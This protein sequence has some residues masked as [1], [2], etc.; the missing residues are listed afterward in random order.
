MGIS[1]N[2]NGYIYSVN[3][4][5]SS[6]YHPKFH[7]MKKYLFLIVLALQGFCAI[8]QESSAFTFMPYFRGGILAIK[9][10]RADAN[11]YTISSEDVTYEG[12]V[13]GGGCEFMYDFNKVSPGID[14]GYSTVFKNSYENI[15]SRSGN[16]SMNEFYVFGFVDLTVAPNLD[17]KFG[18][19]THYA[20]I[21]WELNEGDSGPREG[22]ETGLFFGLLMA[23]EKNIPLENGEI[24]IALKVNPLFSSTDYDWGFLMPLT[25]NLGYRFRM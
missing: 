16:N 19:G 10:T 23:I 3:S 2:L 11:I 24:S 5:L 1:R 4:S 25:L 22:F 14:V 21:E 8:A 18:A 12:G 20:F 9:P 17:F 6:I 15:G 7:I 13:F